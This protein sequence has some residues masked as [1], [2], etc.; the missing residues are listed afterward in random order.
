MLQ[1]IGVLSGKPATSGLHIHPLLNPQREEYKIDDLEISTIDSEL[2]KRLYKDA[3]SVANWR[4]QKRQTS[5]TWHS[6]IGFENVPA[7]YSSLRL[8]N[9]PKTG[10]DTLWA[11][12][13]G[14][15][16]LISQ[17]TQKYL[18]GLTATFKDPGFA[19][20]AERGGYALY[21]KERGS[22][23]NVGTELVGKHPVIRTNP[24]TGWKSVFSISG[25]TTQINEVAPE[26][27]KMLLTWLERLILDN[28]DLHV[29][30]CFRPGDRC[31]PS[32]TFHKIC[33]LSNR[34]LWY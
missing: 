15:Y 34:S 8:V 32:Q 1:K 13:Y 12:G 30:S 3:G 24:V 23:E 2:A 7:D 21:E 31:S 19:K 6:D 22:P 9:I 33:A 5:G 28:H 20:V 18:E 17:P 10:G 16:D 29:S 26:E 4:T 14:I 27:S 11:S 25:H